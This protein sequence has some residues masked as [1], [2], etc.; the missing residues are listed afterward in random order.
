VIVAQVFVS[1]PFYVR[2]ARA[3]LQ[4]VDRELEEAAAA[5][6]AS[7]AQTVGRVT[8]P[9]AAPALGAGLVLAWARALGEFGATIMHCRSSST[10]S[11]RTRSIPRSWQRACSCWR[12]SGS[13]SRYA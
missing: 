12:P 1:A 10:Q 13:S 6:G 5:D 4:G 3:G 9:L 8:I 2:A 11:S 7:G